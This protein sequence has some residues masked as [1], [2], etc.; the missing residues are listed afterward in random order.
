M[1]KEELREISEILES[2]KRMLVEQSAMPLYQLRII[3]IQEDIK[4]E[5]GE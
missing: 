4:R 3:Q 2:F 5:V 1:S